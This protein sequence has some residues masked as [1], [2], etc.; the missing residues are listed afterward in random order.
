MG[1]WAFVYPNTSSC[2]AKQD[3]CSTVIKQWQKY[4]EQTGCGAPLLA[5]DVNNRA[6]PFMNVPPDVI[7]CGRVD[8]IGLDSVMTPD[9]NIF[10]QVVFFVFPFMCTTVAWVVQRVIGRDLASTY[11]NG[12]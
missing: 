9:R 2:A 6:A 10:W 12:T 11:H 4:N 1:I 3:C 8:G 7:S 5:I